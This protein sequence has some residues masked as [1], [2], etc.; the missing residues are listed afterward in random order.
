VTV[1]CPGL[2]VDHSPSSSAEVKKGGAIPALHHMSS[3]PYAYL[4]KHRTTLPFTYYFGVRTEISIRVTIAKN[5]KKNI[6]CLVL[7]SMEIL[8]SRKSHILTTNILLYST[9]I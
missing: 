9:Q 4:I 1:K 3:W 5:S 2:E 6:L 8:Y 7:V